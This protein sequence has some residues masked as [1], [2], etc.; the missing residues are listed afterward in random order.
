M[1]EDEVRKAASPEPRGPRKLDER[2]GPGP[3]GNW[4]PVKGLKKWKK[5]T[6]LHENKSLGCILESGLE[7][8]RM[9]IGRQLGDVC[10][11]D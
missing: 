9:N 4:K 1:I 10:Y 2:F 11:T 6:D 7:R 8:G 3:K 5:M